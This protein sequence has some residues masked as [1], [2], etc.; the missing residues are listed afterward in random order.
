MITSPFMPLIKKALFQ[1]DLLSL[2]EREQY[3]QLLHT[4]EEVKY[5]VGEMIANQIKQQLEYKQSK[6]YAC[7]TKLLKE[8]LDES[9]DDPKTY[10]LAE[11]LFDEFGIVLSEEEQTELYAPHEE[12]E[13]LLELEDI[14]ALTRA[15]NGAYT[16]GNQ[17]AA[18]I[19][20]PNNGDDCTKGIVVKLNKLLDFSLTINIQ[21]NKLNPKIDAEMPPMT[22]E[23]EINF[24]HNKLLP[25]RYYCEITPNTTDTSYDTFILCVFVQKDLMPKPSSI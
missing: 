10:T 22:T 8:V 14:L 20:Q 2:D 11:L 3:H 21:D 9:F 18:I 13:M 23:L 12:E 4:N 24:E 19:I 25:G 6:Q 1:P 16:L 15:S 5:I 7:F 17:L